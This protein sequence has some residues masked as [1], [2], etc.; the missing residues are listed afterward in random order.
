MKLPSSVTILGKRWRLSFVPRLGQQARG[1]CQ[2]PAT[3]SKTI[4]IQSGL[5][6]SELAEVVL[7][8]LLHA[9]NWHLDEE[10]VETFCH[11]ATRALKRM[12]LL[13]GDL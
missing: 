6:G 2:H 13:A 12:G 9:A 3:P 5:R 7:H 8:E 11:D 4:R 10:F 1:D